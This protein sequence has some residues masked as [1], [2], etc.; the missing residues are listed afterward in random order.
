MNQTQILFDRSKPFYPFIMTFYSAIHGSL[1]LVARRTIDILIEN[2]GNPN[3]E[4]LNFVRRMNVE[5]YIGTNKTP[6]LY[7]DK[8]LFE[9]ELGSHIGIELSWDTLSGELYNN[10]DYLGNQLIVTPLRML[11]IGCYEIILESY[12]ANDPEWRFFRHIRNAAAHNG[13]MDFYN[14]R[15]FISPDTRNA[16]W[17]GIEITSDMQGRMLIKTK[18]RIDGIM[19]IG[20]VIQFLHNFERKF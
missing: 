16:S 1:D 15:R 7:T 17:S 6:Y 19:T 10:G 11:I 8:L 9:Y 18:D 13:Q 5:R 3:D 4:R 2:G 20:E 12:D 14:G